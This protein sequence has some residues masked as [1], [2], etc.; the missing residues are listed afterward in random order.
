MASDEWT[1]FAE[2]AAASIRAIEATLLHLESAPATPDELHGLYRGLHTLKGSSGFLSL[3]SF[4][5]VAHAC[6]E[7]VGLARDRGVP[8]DAEMLELLLEALDTLRDATAILVREQRDVEPET[9][10]DLVERVMRAFHARGGAVQAPLAA[11]L[12]FFDDVVDEPAPAE[13][14]RRI[15]SFKPPASGRPD[16]PLPRL[17]ARPVAPRKLAMR[18]DPH[19]ES[20]RIDGTKVTALMDLA[21]ELGLA[22]SAVTR[23]PQVGG[24]KLDGFSSAAHKLELLV[25]EIQNDLSA[26]RLVP[27]EP[28][29]QR[30]RRVVRD[31]AKATHK[32]IEL[33]I[34]GDDTEVDKV[35]LD[36]I[37][38]P[39]VH[40]LRNAIDHGVEST[41]GRAAAGKPACGRITLS[42]TQLGGE[43]SIEVRDDGRGID[44]ERVLERARARGLW[45]EAGEPTDAEITSFLFMPGFSTKESVDE[46]S[47]RGV[48]MDVVK[49]TVERLRG[50]VTM[51]SKPGL[52]SRITMTMP[53]TLAF[54]EAMVVR[55]HGRL[56]ALPIEKVLEVSKV[57]R[58]Q[59]V[60]NIADGQVSL[61]VR[62][63]C[64]PVVWLHE[65]WG[66]A[67]RE[68]RDLHGCLVALVQ[69]SS[70]A[71]TIPVDELLGNQQVMLKPLRGSLAKIRAAS[72]CGMLRTGDVAIALDCDQLHA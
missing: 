39:L 46:M 54:V 35:M 69:T 11:E 48:G 63:S 7:L 51:T 6:E 12:V 15:K 26:L 57:D 52:G 13:L 61:R 19:T 16:K 67:A 4:G 38:D 17:T 72:G 62:E 23:H 24:R 30:M 47:G 44:R 59:V 66:E 20:L 1:V 9:V 60:T 70:G 34:V 42:A 33:V 27:V 28:L 8:F 31:A 43:V 14:V 71:V 41:P 22:C 45:R 10:D 64:L 53:L 2:E 55:E 65:F 32:E 3:R 68:T 37:Q 40:V 50:R 18:S 49:T 58:A 25:R 29:F 5:R 21:G 56:F 36:A